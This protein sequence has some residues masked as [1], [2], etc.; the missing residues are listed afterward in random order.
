MTFSY[1]F[2]YMVSIKLDHVKTAGYYCTITTSS[3]SGPLLMKIAYL[4]YSFC[5]RGISLTWKTWKYQDTWII[6]KCIQSLKI[7]L[8][9]YS[10]MSHKWLEESW[11]CIVQKLWEP[12]YPFKITALFPIFMCMIYVVRDNSND[13]HESRVKQLFITVQSDGLVEK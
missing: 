13:L 7:M 12:W 9:S 8:L 3:W 4:S 10:S 2:I 6:W 11:K 1:I 5:K